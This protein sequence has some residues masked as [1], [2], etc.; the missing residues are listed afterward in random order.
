MHIFLEEYFINILNI[1]VKH[2]L[3]PVVQV[4]WHDRVSIGVTQWTVLF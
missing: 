4:D 3:K 1:L 2:L